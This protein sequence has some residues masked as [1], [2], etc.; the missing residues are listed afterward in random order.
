MA[1][2]WNLQDFYAGSNDPRIMQDVNSYR[3][4]VEEFAKKYKGRISSL[5][6]DE[7]LAYLQDTSNLGNIP[8]KIS[9]YIG[10]AMS[11]DT[12]DQEL[13]KLSKRLQKLES[14]CLEQLTFV[15]EEHKSLGHERFIEL[16]R[17]PEF[18]RYRNYLVNQ[19]SDLKYILSEKEEWLLIKSDQASAENLYE[20]LTSTFEFP[21]RGKVLTFDEVRALRESHDREER[22]DAVRSI[23]SVF[24]QQER[25]IVLGNLYA[26]V[27]KANVFGKDVRGYASV[28]SP[29]NESEEVSD[30]AVNKL[31]DAVTRS[32]PQFHR[33][34]AMKKRMLGLDEFRLCDVF[35]PVGELK[36]DP[37]PFEKGWK[38]FMDVIKDMDPEQ[39]RFAQSMLD[40]G[41]ISVFPRKGKTTGAYA[42]YGPRSKEFMLLNWADGPGDVTTLSHEMG[43][44][45]HGYLS[46]AQDPL[47]YHTPLTLAETASIFNET[48]MFESLLAKADPS[49]RNTMIVSRLDDIFATIF[50]QI[51]FIRFERRC[52]ESFDNNEPMTYSDFND[53]WMEEMELSYGPDVVIDPKLMRSLWSSI[54]H[55]FHTPFYCYT[56]AFGNII[57]LN[58]VQ[59]YKRADD[60]GEFMQKYHRFLSAGGSNRPE[61]LLMKVFGIKMDEQFYETAFQSIAD[62]MDMIEETV[63]A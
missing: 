41:R 2:E 39:H 62:L 40:E 15:D 45:M 23:A 30:D 7:F 42:N 49:Q 19:A 58:L 57:S 25:Q 24:D 4:V 28:M 46:K 13:Q 9:L 32:Y 17:L 1:T 43:H 56:Y 60:K 50:R 16:S 10:L 53:A 36:S 18:E 37:V 11:V 27:C 31:I 29:R 44:C 54:S 5:T 3:K 52:H 48:L 12:Q 59:Q 35:A 22:E 38:M 33:F 8:E 21:F 26:L 6:K 34:L 63:E 14:D 47:V 51:C 20:E 55:I 61:D